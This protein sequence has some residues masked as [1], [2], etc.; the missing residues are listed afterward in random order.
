MGILKENFDENIDKLEPL[1][2]NEP[3]NKSNKESSKENSNK[4]PTKW[5]SKKI[6]K[7]DYLVSETESIPSDLEREPMIGSMQGSTAFFEGTMKL[8]SK[9]TA[10]SPS[11]KKNCSN[12]G[13]NGYLQEQMLYL[14]E[15]YVKLFG[16]YDNSLSATDQEN[17]KSDIAFIARRIFTFFSLPLCLY[18]TYNWFFVL[19]YSSKVNTQIKIIPE[20]KYYKNWVLRPLNVE[21]FV[22]KPL[23]LYVFEFPFRPLIDLDY[24]LLAPVKNCIDKFVSGYLHLFLFYVLFVMF[25]SFESGFC[26]ISEPENINLN[27]TPKG[28]DGEYDLCGD[29]LDNPSKQNVK[30]Q[31]KVD[32][33]KAKKYSSSIFNSIKTYSI[34]IITFH[35]LVYVVKFTSNKIF[36]VNL[37]EAAELLQE[38]INGGINGEISKMAG[39]MTGEMSGGAGLNPNMLQVGI[40]PVIQYPFPFNIILIVLII[41][42][43]YAL[44]LTLNLS[45]PFLNLAAYSVLIYLV[46][47]SFFAI[48]YYVGFTPYIVMTVIISIDKFLQNGGKVTKEEV[49]KCIST[50]LWCKVGMFFSEFF[51][52]DKFSLLCILYFIFWFFQTLVAVKSYS[53][54]ISTAIIFSLLIMATSAYKYYKTRLYVLTELG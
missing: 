53:L 14:A 22:V 52:R 8:F 54:K 36:G 40:P 19:F 34:L 18:V 9:L 5:N 13:L 51:S 35:W 1:L 42:F 11:S 48:M 49:P 3:K 29:E 6:S 50:D 21:T 24:F 4:E 12:P 30:F 47:Y 16:D 46:F 41:I 44:R 32:C 15:N 20:I 43:C 28:K 17:K 27:E 26:E 38:G 2:N 31:S 10:S 7:K 25:M 23:L 33:D 45:D 39:K 37:D